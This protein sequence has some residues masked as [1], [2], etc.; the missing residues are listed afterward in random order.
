[1]GFDTIEE[2]AARSMGSILSGLM[3]GSICAFDT[4]VDDGSIYRYDTFVSLVSLLS[5]W[6]YLLNGVKVSQG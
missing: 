3:A 2:N 6:H 4:F 5:V 1:M